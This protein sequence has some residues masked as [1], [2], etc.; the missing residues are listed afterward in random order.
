MQQRLRVYSQKGKE[1]ENECHNV[2][3]RLQIYRFRFRTAR[4]IYI[5]QCHFAWCINRHD[6]YMNKYRVEVDGLLPGITDTRSDLLIYSFAGKI[7][8]H[9]FDVS[10][11]RFD[12]VI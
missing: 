4:S 8:F 3:D 5:R 1:R 12:S 2:I 6:M 11:T 9:P 7:Y 10:C